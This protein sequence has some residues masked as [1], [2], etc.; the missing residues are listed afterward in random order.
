MEFCGI[1]ALLKELVDKIDFCGDRNSFMD[2]RS[3]A[4]IQDSLPRGNS[5]CVKFNRLKS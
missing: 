5:S 1:A 3:L 2:S 4:H